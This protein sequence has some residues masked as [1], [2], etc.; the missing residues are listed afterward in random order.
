MGKISDPSEMDKFEILNLKRSC[1][2][3]HKLPERTPKPIGV[4]E[5]AFLGIWSIL[6]SLVQ[7][8]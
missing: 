7:E 3:Y 6:R 2:K 1:L 8:N 5:E 4:R